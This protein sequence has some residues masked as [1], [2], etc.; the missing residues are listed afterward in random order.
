M[1]EPW[2]GLRS[3]QRPQADLRNGYRGQLQVPPGLQDRSQGGALGIDKE[4]VRLFHSPSPV[5]IDLAR[6]PYGRTIAGGRRR[7]TLVEKRE[8]RYSGLY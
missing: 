3:L 5:P 7:L 4:G 1:G 8:D 6:S 2:G